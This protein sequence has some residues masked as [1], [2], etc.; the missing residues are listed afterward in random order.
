MP[1]ASKP[2][3]GEG[4]VPESCGINGSGNV[5]GR[6]I[7]NSRLAAQKG[8]RGAAK[9]S[10]HLDELAV[11]QRRCHFSAAVREEVGNGRCNNFVLH[12]PLHA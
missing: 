3:S 9:V 8:G 6:W 10:A 7:S 5:N 2:S 4:A 1:I 11:R 12:S